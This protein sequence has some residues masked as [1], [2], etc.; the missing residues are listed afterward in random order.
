MEE[1]KYLTLGNKIGYGMGEVSGNLFNAL[2]SNFYMIFLTNTVGRN[3][4]VVKHFGIL[5][6]NLIS[7]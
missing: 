3:P 6:Y 7:A 4:M 1:K 2:V 5:Q